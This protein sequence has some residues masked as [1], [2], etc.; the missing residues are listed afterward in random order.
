[1]G[2]KLTTQQVMHQFG[3]SRR[4]VQ[5]YIHSGKLI[6]VKDAQG[7][8]LFHRHQVEAVQNTVNAQ[9]T[10]QEAVQLTFTF[11]PA[12]QVIIDREHYEGLLCR[13]AQVETEKR[14]LTRKIEDMRGL[15][16]KAI[17][18][19]TVVDTHAEKASR[20][21]GDDL[22][23]CGPAIHAA[24]LIGIDDPPETSAPWWTRPGS[25]RPFWKR[26]FSR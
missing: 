13:L 15:E 18:E 19:D 12:K 10:V 9:H 21:P 14:F 25:K 26:W 2:E 8:N 4:T 20:K 3:V 24:T 23:P 7:R 17:A 11:N 5:A 6:P 22:P 1:M 16:E